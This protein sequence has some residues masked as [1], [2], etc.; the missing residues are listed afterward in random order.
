M[1]IVHADIAF[2]SGPAARDGQHRPRLLRAIGQM[3]SG[4]E[5]ARS[6][7]AKLK[8]LASHEAAMLIGCP[9]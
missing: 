3:E 1:E 4:L 8:L 2:L 7:P 9:F 6:V 5:A